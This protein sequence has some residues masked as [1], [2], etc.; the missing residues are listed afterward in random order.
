[1]QIIQ[2]YTKQRSWCLYKKTKS[3]VERLDPWIHIKSTVWTYTGRVHS[4]K[5]IFI[6]TFLGSGLWSGLFGLADGL[7]SAESNQQKVNTLKVCT[8]IVCNFDCRVV[9]LLIKNHC[10]S[11]F[12][13]HLVACTWKL[14]I[15]SKSAILIGFM[16]K[17]YNS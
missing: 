14:K 10:H 13:L 3:S 9:C 4:I 6:F 2:N 8:C 11:K 15:Q 7:F 16:N 17:G 12:L 5:I 1:M